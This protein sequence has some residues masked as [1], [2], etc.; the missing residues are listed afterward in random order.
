MEN[1]SSML[2]EAAAAEASKKLQSLRESV[3]SVIFG[4]E[5]LVDLVIV[6]LLSRGHILLEGLPGLGK[7]EMVKTFS[8]LLG[9]GTGRVQFTPDLLPGDI[10]G[11]PMLDEVDGQRKFVFQKGPVFTN[12][13]LADEINRASPKTQSA[14]LEAMQEQSVTVANESHRLPKPFFVFATQN[15]IEL[16]G[17]Y[18]LPEAQLDRF[19]FKLEV[20]RVGAGV[21]ERIIENRRPGVEVRIEQMM[22]ADVLNELIQTSNEVYLPN[23]VARY[24]ARLVESTHPGELDGNELVKFGA[25]PRAAIGMAAAGRAHALLHG[26]L[27][28]SCED[29]QFVAPHILGH[30][31][32]M[33]YQARMEGLDPKRFVEGLL[34]KVS[35][36]E[37]PLPRSL[38][39]AKLP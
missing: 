1:T 10:T 5:K 31:V 7:T 25:S 38:S 3:N 36:E 15:P 12:L 29:V 33:N 16:E 22:S 27:H 11:S 18:P 30:R 9:L 24:I 34:Q 39:T 19:L 17:T 2:D 37:A 28:V 6:A 26:R 20:T 13:L 23:V 32:V 35:P 8:G 4:Q 21:L 14:L